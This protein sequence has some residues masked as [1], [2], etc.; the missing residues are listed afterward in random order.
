VSS[1]Y[2]F[3]FIHFVPLDAKAPKFFGFSEFLSALALMVLAWTIADVRYRFRVKITPFPLQRI[4]FSVV[5]SIGILTLINDLWRA[6][7][8]PVLQG[9]F[10]SQSVWQALLGCLFLLTFLTWAW[11]AFIKPPVYNKRNAF[12]YS[13]TLFEYILRGSPAELSIIADEF[14]RSVRNLIQYATD[15]DLFEK[16]ALMR[17]QVRVTDYADD[18]LLL[19]GDKRFCRAIIESSPSTALIFFEE[20]SKTKKYSVK[21][22]SFAKNIVNEALMNKDSF[23]FHETE[24]Y[25]SGLI[26]YYKPLSNTIFSNYRMVEQIGSLPKC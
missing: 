3:R 19:I 20:I 23:L 12:R 7:R 13:E 11:F 14:K 26:G 10:M 24:G 25:D 1:E 17:K 2:I 15:I 22:D 18:I 4:T 6:E 9:N 5:A 21:I 16:K 8:W